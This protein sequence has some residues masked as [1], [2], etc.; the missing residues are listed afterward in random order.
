M[1][2]MNLTLGGSRSPNLPHA[3]LQKFGLPIHARLPCGVIEAVRDVQEHRSNI[4]IPCPVTFE[5]IV[6]GIVLASVLPLENIAAAPDRK[7][8]HKHDN[9]SSLCSGRPPDIGEIESKAEDESSKHLSQPVQR[10]VESASTR[11]EAREIDVVDLVGVEP[12]GGEEHGK[13]EY[14]V[15]IAPKCLPKAEDLRFPR[16]LLH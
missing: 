14:D 9:P 11:V 6:F 4:A 13:E 5:V 16:R 7:G 2:P 3:R 10:A 1:A 15:W 8:E 12:I